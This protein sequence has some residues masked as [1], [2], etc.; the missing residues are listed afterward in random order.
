MAA[1]GRC[2]HSE[3]AKTASER[4]CSLDLDVERMAED[5]PAAQSLER[6]RRAKASER[7]AHRTELHAVAVLEHRLGRALAAYGHAVGGAGV[8]HRDDVLV[9]GEPSMQARNAGIV[10]DDVGGCA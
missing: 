5:R 7:D 10:D 2:A 9:E 6:A 8:L 1:S 4:A 3:Q